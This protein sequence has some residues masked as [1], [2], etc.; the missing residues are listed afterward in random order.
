M[1]NE[2][3]TRRK[4]VVPKL[5]AAGW[6]SNPHS[7]TDDKSFTGSNACRQVQRRFCYTRDVPLA[8][9]ESEATRKS[10]ADG[11]R[12]ASSAHNRTLTLG[13]LGRIEVRVAPLATQ[14]TFDHPQ[15]KFTAF[16]AEHAGLRA[17]NATLFGAT[18][19]RIFR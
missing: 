2:A 16:M 18:L 14:R 1:I 19:E 6:D 13:S 15:A 3:D 17:A 9:V 7:L 10:P 4:Y 8:L 5:Q 11:L 12:P